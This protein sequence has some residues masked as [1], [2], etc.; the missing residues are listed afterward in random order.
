MTGRPGGSSSGAGRPRDTPGARPS[1]TP[2]QGR[3]RDTSGRPRNARPR[4]ALGRP[5]PR[6]ATG[7]QRV[8]DDL[9]VPPEEALSMAQRLLDTGRPFHAHEVLEASWKAAPPAE[10]ELWKGLA[11]IAV[12]IT[13]ARRGNAQGAV[14]LLRRGGQRVGRY[15]GTAPH[16]IDAAGIAHQASGLAD[17]IDRDGLAAAAGDGSAFRLT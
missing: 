14:A 13:H 10:R 2:G 16:G 5:L 1:R 15:A 9:A 11:Q 6:G 17:R 4:D 7:E 3:D 12:G 8:P